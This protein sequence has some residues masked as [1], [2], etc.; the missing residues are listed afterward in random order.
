MPFVERF[1][2]A[3]VLEAFCLARCA[4][5]VFAAVLERA[6]VRFATDFT[7]LAEVRFGCVFA[8][9]DFGFVAGLRGV[10]RAVR[11]AGLATGCMAVRVCF[12]SLARVAPDCRS[13][14]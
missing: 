11:C 1:A 7:A 14:K 2:T 6:G 3:F 13:L 8:I 5:R 4:C 9:A 12:P 10:V